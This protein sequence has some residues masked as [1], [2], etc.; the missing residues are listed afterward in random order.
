VSWMYRVPELPADVLDALA[1]R[2]YE[3]ASNMKCNGIDVFRKLKNGCCWPRAR[4]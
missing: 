3:M 2:D 1:L 4:S